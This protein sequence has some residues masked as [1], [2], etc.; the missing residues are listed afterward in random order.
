MYTEPRS[1]TMVSGR[2]T[3]RAAANSN[4]ASMLS[5]RS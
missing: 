3:G 4:R 5:N 1:H 2:I